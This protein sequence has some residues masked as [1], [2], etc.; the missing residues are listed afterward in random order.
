M[1]SQP[2]TQTLKSAAGASLGWGIVM[3]ILGLAAMFLPTVAG[4][5]VSV[6]FGWIIVLGGFAYIASA[7]SARGAGGF[8]WR[9]LI[10]VVYVVGGLFLAVHTGIA[11][12]GLTLAMTIMFFF[13]GIL[14]IVAFF[15]F[16]ALSGSGWI[17]ADGIVT[18]ILAYL[19]WRPWPISSIWAIGTILGINLITSGITRVMY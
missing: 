7:F 13:E 16:R 5:G 1:S 19:I 12:A 14:E 8:I 17:L 15:E 6:A 10:G 2:I 18:L 9:V 4:I 3:I 11:L